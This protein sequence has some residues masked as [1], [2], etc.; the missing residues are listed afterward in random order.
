MLEAQGKAGE[1]FA[2]VEQRGLIAA[3][4]SEV[5]AGNDRARRIGGFYE[6]LLDL[7]PVVD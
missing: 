4:V 6:E 2:A 7:G 5:P 3:G 1:L